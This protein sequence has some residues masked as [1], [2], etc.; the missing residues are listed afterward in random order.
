MNLLG[1]FAQRIKAGLEDKKDGVFLPGTRAFSITN[2]TPRFMYPLIRAAILGPLE[3]FLKV[4][5]NIR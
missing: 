4:Q 1:L 2:R 3:N 5:W